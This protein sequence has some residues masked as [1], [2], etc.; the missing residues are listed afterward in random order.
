MQNVTSA[1]VAR[2]L[3]AAVGFVSWV[4]AQ[5]E[6]PTVT[7]S[8]RC[9]IVDMNEG[10]AVADVNRDGKPDIIAGEHWYAA[11]DFIPRPVRHIPPVL[12]LPAYLNG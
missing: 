4:A 8:K 3:L 1:A 9:L 5:A 12:D 11:P 10:C 7:F 6:S 2:R